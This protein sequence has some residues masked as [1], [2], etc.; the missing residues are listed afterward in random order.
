MKREELP[1][2]EW[3]KGLRRT[4]LIARKI[5]QYPLWKKDG[6]KIRTTL[7]QIVDNHVIKYIP[8]EE[9]KPAQVP[10]VKKLSNF[11]C[12]L[13]GSESIDPTLLTKEYTNLFKDSGVMPKRNIN[14]FIISPQAEL[15]PGTQ[16]NVTH[17]RVGDYVDVRG[18][19]YVFAQ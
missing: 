16:L 7:L 9:Y 3:S 1:P 8:P 15:L 2:Q 11:G 17:F 13:I 4:G 14:R 12:L 18:K 19:T 6:T 5:G 10:D